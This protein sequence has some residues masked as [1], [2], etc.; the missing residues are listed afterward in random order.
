MKKR[1]GELAWS[2]SIW[3]GLNSAAVC[4]GF[5]SRRMLIT[6][7][8]ICAGGSV[9]RTTSCGVPGKLLRPRIVN[10][11]AVLAFHAL[12]VHV[13]GDADHHADPDPCS[14]LSRTCPTGSLFGQ[15]A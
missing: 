3:I 7:F 9:V 14:P 11:P 13:L 5:I 12:R 2:T 6:L 1:R 10:L 15:C 4:F 8:A